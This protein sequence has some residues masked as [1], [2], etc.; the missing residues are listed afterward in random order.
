MNE[1]LMNEQLMNEQS[2]SDFVEGDDDNNADTQQSTLWL[3]AFHNNNDN[4]NEATLRS[5][6]FNDNSVAAIGRR[7]VELNASPRASGQKG[8]EWIIRLRRRKKK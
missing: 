7:A 8:E 2:M 6:A 4:D 1:Q 5:D 3:D